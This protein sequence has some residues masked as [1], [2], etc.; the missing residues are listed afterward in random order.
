MGPHTASVG[1]N[2]VQITFVNVIV[3]S[4]GWVVHSFSS[5]LLIKHYQALFTESAILWIGVST[6]GSCGLS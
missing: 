3:V 1:G 2:S 4:I 6:V 5:N